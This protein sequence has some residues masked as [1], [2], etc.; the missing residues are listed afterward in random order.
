MS[1]N[2]FSNNSVTEAA[3]EDDSS[4]TSLLWI[5]YVT[6]AGVFVGFLCVSFLR[7]HQRHRE[8][9]QRKMSDEDTKL[10]LKQRTL[11]HLSLKSYRKVNAP[12]VVS[13]ET[14]MGSSQPDNSRCFETDSRKDYTLHRQENMAALN[15]PVRQA[16]VGPAHEIFTT[17]LKSNKV[18]VDETIRKDITGDRDDDMSDIR[19]RYDRKDLATTTDLFSGSP[20]WRDTRCS[21][22][23]RLKGSSRSPPTI[24][25]P[26]WIA[27][28]QFEISSVSTSSEQLYC[29]PEGCA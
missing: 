27:S 17:D 25:L 12:N 10:R 7:Y 5:P 9:Y 1:V 15:S 4:E 2:L 16:K 13:T 20:S 6:I 21:K 19:S 23:S 18:S 28:E 11:K 24:S 29:L 14:L 22:N 8:R 3:P 26:I